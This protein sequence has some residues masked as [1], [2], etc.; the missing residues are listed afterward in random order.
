MKKPRILIMDIESSLAQFAGFGPIQPY[1]QNKNMIKDF[2]ILTIAWHWLG[3]DVIHVDSVSKS[4]MWDDKTLLKR[5]RKVIESADVV[6]G[7]N[8]DR[9]DKKKI[10]GRSMSNGLEPIIFPPSVDTL[11]VAKKAFALTYNKLDY[12]AELL[13]VSRKME[14]S[15]GLWMRILKGDS[16]ALA[17]MKK[18]NIQDVEVQAEVYM[19]L[20]PFIENHPNMNV[21]LGS[22]TILCKNCG[23]NHL[24]KHGD[25][26]NNTSTYQRYK[27]QDCGSITRDKKAKKV[28]NGR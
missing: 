10:Q 21:I 12:I 15:P 16:S 9:F 17:E 4:R 8:W 22:D 14:T 11:K 24:H 2:N 25:Y 27:C 1:I 7:H 19:A 3:E 28:Y 18:Y 23:S 5:V 26:R 13:G 20:L 6:V